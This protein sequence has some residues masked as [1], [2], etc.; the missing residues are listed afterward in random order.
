MKENTILNMPRKS[1]NG[2]ADDSMSRPLLD[3]GE[4]SVD[5][6]LLEATDRESGLSTREAEKRLKTYGYNELAEKERNPLLEFLSNFWGPMPIMIWIAVI[7]EGIQKDWADFFVLLALQ[8]V[9]GLVSWHEHSKAADAIAALKSSLSPQAMVKRDGEWRKV[10]ARILVP[11]DLVSLALGS[12]VPADTQVIGPKLVYADQAALTGESLPVK[13]KVGEIAKMGSNITTGEAEGIVAATGGRTFFGR[14]ATLINDVE[15]GGHFQLVLYRITA[16]LMVVSIILTGIIM[17]YM[18]MNADKNEK[19]PFLNALSIC[20]VLLVASIPIAMQVV[21]TS[22]MAIGSRRLA[23][24]K[25]IVTRLASI[26]ELAGMD[27]LCS[28]KT[29]TLT[30]GVMVMKDTIVINKDA[31]KEDVLAMAAL[32][33]KWKEPARDAIDKLVLGEVVKLDMLNKLNLNSQV[34]YVPFDPKTKRTESTIRDKDG[35][36]F[37][38]TKGA[39]Q[40]VLGLCRDC[41]D[42]KRKSIKATI[43]DLANR[44]IRSLGIA[45]TRDGV[46]FEFL[47]ILTFSDPPRHD[48]KDTI[49]RAQELGIE[50]KMIT[51]DQV[52]IAKETCY[53]LGMGTN[54]QGTDVIPLSNAGANNPVSV[55]FEELIVS[56]DG[57]AE[58]YPEHKYLIVKSL[59]NMGFRC[60]MTGDG[61]NDAPALKR[62]D[63]GIAVQ[64]ATDAARAAADI[65]LTEPGLSVIIDAIVLSRKI[66]HRMKNYVT[67]RIACTIQ[68]LLFFFIAIL[69]FH[70]DDFPH[71]DLSSH[72]RHHHPKNYYDFSSQTMVN[73][74]IAQQQNYT[75]T[76]PAPVVTTTPSSD[77][78]LP[79]Y[80]KLPVIALVLITI[81]NDGTIITIAYDNVVPGSEPEKWHLRR[82]YLESALLG[83]VACVSSLVLLWIAMN[84]NGDMDAFRDWFHLEPLNYNQVKCLMYLKISLSD[85]LTVFAARTQGW[86]FS[87]RPGY[88]LLSAFIVATATSS[89]LSITWPGNTGDEKDIMEA[90]SYKHMGIVWLYCIIWFF[91]QD[92]CKMILH[93][94]D[95]PLV[96]DTNSDLVTQQRSQFRNARRKLD[97]EKVARRGTIASPPTSPMFGP[98][99]GRRGSILGNSGYGDNLNSMETV[100][101]RIMDMEAE[102]VVLRN[103]VMRMTGLNVQGPNPLDLARRLDT[104]DNNNNSNGRKNSRSLSEENA[105]NNMDGNGGKGFLQ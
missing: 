104:S 78:T 45:R 97:E 19:D 86:F 3:V 70:P 66:F 101:Q 26:E 30:L 57:F 42:A 12:S 46:G 23:E 65:V 25:A 60:G 32:A 91:I 16:F 29:G 95:R 36:E 50:V 39:P 74:F 58:V 10:N 105:R 8:L 5:S 40:V 13:I 64:G 94:F 35:K 72:H 27:M 55:R 22:T 68:L 75:A 20:V 77:F 71:M 90:I 18:I 37:K 34:D 98:K 83:G 28:D 31:T 1:V 82:V 59:R 43:A 24:K 85:F 4:D 51:G 48:T 62:A 93:Q 69:S 15:E 79:S 89:V 11:G 76:T 56:A 81:L 2:G 84:S 14:T 21:C 88:A 9:N 7:I 54:I 17:G 47:G 87:R 103:A 6:T 38:V 52:A 99:D 92:I 53:E 63:I 49:E 73:P 44:G 33:A 100:L 41:D 96:T 61:V 67:Y 102:L 80:F